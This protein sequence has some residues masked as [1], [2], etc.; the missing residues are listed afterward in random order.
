M[1]AFIVFVLVSSLL[2]EKLVGKTVSEMTYFVEWDVKLHVR[3]T[4]DNTANILFS[5]EV[6]V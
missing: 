2:A 5:P 1:F 4:L 6:V 3:S